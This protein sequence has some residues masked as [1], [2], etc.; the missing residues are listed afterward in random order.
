MDATVAEVM[1]LRYG[2]F[3]GRRRV[4][5]GAARSGLFA[6]AVAENRRRPSVYRH[7]ARLAIGHLECNLRPPSDILNWH[8][9]AIINPLQVTRLD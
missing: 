3:E 6:F 4:A 1:L 9:A 2:K 5:K 7:A 8:V